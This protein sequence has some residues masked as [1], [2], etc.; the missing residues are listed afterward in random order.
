[1]LHDMCFIE[2]QD[3]TSF[4]SNSNLTT[5][6]TETEYEDEMDNTPTMSLT[7]PCN[8][9]LRIPINPELTPQDSDGHNTT[10]LGNE[11]HNMDNP[12]TLLHHSH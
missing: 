9:D 3:T 12:S 10:T 7:S 2:T 5:V 6:N 1:M 4:P 8:E 11:L